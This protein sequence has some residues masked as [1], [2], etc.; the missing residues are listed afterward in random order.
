MDKVRQPLFPPRAE[1]AWEQK[2]LRHSEPTTGGVGWNLSPGAV[3]SSRRNTFLKCPV[4]GALASLHSRPGADH[5][6][7]RTILAAS[8]VQ[9]IPCPDQERGPSVYLVQV[10]P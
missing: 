6:E 7:P 2:E 9:L 5:P 8:P 1:G 3:F 4:G 10:G